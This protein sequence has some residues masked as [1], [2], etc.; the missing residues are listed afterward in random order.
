MRTRWS[1]IH[2]LITGR[3]PFQAPNA[4]GYLSAHLTQDP[5]APGSVSAGIPPA[6]DNL[7][8]ALLR[9]DPDQRY[10]NAADLAQALL[11]LGSTGGRTLC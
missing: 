11:Q 6:W 3:A 5:P 2:E 4:A 8:L 9:K 1:T 10:P 7:V